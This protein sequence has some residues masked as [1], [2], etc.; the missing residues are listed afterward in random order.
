[1][2]AVFILQ[3]MTCSSSCSL[4][5]A[6]LFSW[7]QATLGTHPFTTPLT[8]QPLGS[9]TSSWYAVTSCSN[10]ASQFLYISKIKADILLFVWLITAFNKKTLNKMSKSIQQ[11]LW[12]LSTVLSESYWLECGTFTSFKIILHSSVY[13]Y[14]SPHL[15]NIIFLDWI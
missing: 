12:F 13:P 1:M 8:L 10:A 4:Q 15:L 3:H 6:L 2:L 14:S 9:H 5:S 7:V 11:V